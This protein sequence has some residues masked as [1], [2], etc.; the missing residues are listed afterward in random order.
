MTKNYMAE[1]RTLTGYTLEEVV[2]EM[3]KVLPPGGYKEIKGQGVKL[4]DI[5]PSYLD[6]ALTRV[7]GL[8]GVGWRYNYS[9]P[10]SYK[11]ERTRQDKSKYTMYGV[12]I[13]N[14]WLEFVYIDLD[15]ERHWSAAIV[16]AGGS[17]NR[18]LSYAMK[19]AITNALGTAATKLLWQILVFTGKLD[20]TN[21]VSAYKSQQARLGEPEAEKVEAPEEVVEDDE[22]FAVKDEEPVG[23][24]ED[25]TVSDEPENEPESDE[26]SLPDFPA[27]GT[28]KEKIDW[29]KAVVLDKSLGLPL[30]GKTLGEIE[31]N[32]TIGESLITFLVGEEANASGEK[33][34]PQTRYQK[35]LQGAASILMQAKKKEAEKE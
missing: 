30:G 10:E 16:G 12:T 18:V 22:D 17:E 5:N 1:Y 29:S 7:F 26:V 21:A 31:K 35:Q 11:D 23:D 2:Q 24:T 6:I 32:K 34:N 27:Q 4:T 14:F 33:F 28:S 19:G 8:I 13:T 3:A 20:H 15:G 25:A 9:S